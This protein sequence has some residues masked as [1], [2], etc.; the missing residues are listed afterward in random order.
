M[1]T[2]NHAANPQPNPFVVFLDGIANTGSS[3]PPIGTVDIGESVGSYLFR[4]ALP[5]IPKGMSFTQIG[6][7]M[8]I[9]M[10]SCGILEN[11]SSVFQMHVEQIC[12]PG[13]FCI[14]F[15]LPGEVDARMVTSTYLP[16]AILEVTVGKRQF[17]DTTPKMADRY[18]PESTWA[19]WGVM[20]V[21]P[22]QQKSPHPINSSFNIEKNKP[23]LLAETERIKPPSRQSS[24]SFDFYLRSRFSTGTLIGMSLCRRLSKI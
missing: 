7:K 24:R 17:P 9:G 18:G 3:G 6:L 2:G 11:S 12:P 1:D 10:L 22:I 21:G 8:A 16:G 23:K 20:I 13:P 5:G 19:K 4:V 15:S 14:S